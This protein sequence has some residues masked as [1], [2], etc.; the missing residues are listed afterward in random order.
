MPKQYIVWN[1]DGERREGIETWL[2][3]SEVKSESQVV[4]GDSWDDVE[5]QSN[6]C[7]P[8]E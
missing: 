8:W 4:W 3:K 7:A 2:N 1:V 6:E 5:R